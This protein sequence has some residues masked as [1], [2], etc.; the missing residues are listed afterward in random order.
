M[1]TR[2]Q[3]ERAAKRLNINTSKIPVEKLQKGMNLE[4]REHRAALNGSVTR[5]AMIARDHL[6]SDRNAY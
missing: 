5:A 1:I 3:A 2:K 4:M 6:Q